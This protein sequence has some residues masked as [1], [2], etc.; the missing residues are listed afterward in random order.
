[1]SRRPPCA[2]RR[3]L[4]AL[5]A[6]LAFLAL[7]AGCGGSSGAATDPLPSTS[8]AGAPPDLAQFLQLPPATPSACPSTVSGSTDGRS[9]PW[10]GQVD[11]SVFI[12]TSA[13]PATAT[14]LGV[15]LRAEPLVARVYFESRRQAFEEFQRLYT[16]W[17]SVPRSQTPASYRV[18]LVP[19]ATLL[20]RNALVARLVNQP[21][22]DSVVCAPA[23]PCTSIQRTS[24][25]S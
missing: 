14:K 25:G 1:V 19:T 3:R 17:A 13:S 21:G 6:P 15:G 11:L 8:D 9:S 10:V 23:I 22:V 5:V 16:C 18:I 24:P 4:V 2:G 7:A 20:Q 12:A